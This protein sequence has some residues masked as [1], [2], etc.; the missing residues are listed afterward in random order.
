MMVHVFLQMRQ[1]QQDHDNLVVTNKSLAEYNLSLQPRIE[2]LIQTVGRGYE[3]VNQAKT[4]LGEHK[5]TLGL[6]IFT[7]HN[8]WITIVPSLDNFVEF[9]NLLIHFIYIRGV[10][11]SPQSLI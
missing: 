6:C 5:A 9:L 7:W 4:T 2:D 3:E 10:C 8:Q 11:I 1:V